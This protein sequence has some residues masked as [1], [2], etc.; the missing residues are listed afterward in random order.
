MEKLV[1]IPRNKQLTRRRTKKGRLV[2]SVVVGTT[3]HYELT[4]NKIFVLIAVIGPVR[5]LRRE[6]ANE[7][8]GSDRGDFGGAEGG[9]RAAAAFSLSSSSLLAVT[10]RALVVVALPD[11]VEEDGG[12]EHGAADEERRLGRPF[13]LFGHSACGRCRCSVLFLAPFPLPL[14]A[15]QFSAEGNTR[16]TVFSLCWFVLMSASLFVSPAVVEKV[17]MRA[18]RFKVRTIQKFRTFQESTANE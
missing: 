6:V 4:L 9:V 3:T 16:L 7:T 12:A 18:C 2:V 5:V 11:C 15:L 8:G 10:I 14:F 13:L 17:V 1:G